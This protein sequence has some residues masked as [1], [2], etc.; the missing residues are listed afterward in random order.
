MPKSATEL[1]QMLALVRPLAQ[2]VEELTWH[3]WR[4]WVAYDCAHAGT[5][6]GPSGLTSEQALAVLDAGVDA[7][8]EAASPGVWALSATMA[9]ALT[10]LCRH[11][12]EHGYGPQLPAWTDAA[13]GVRHHFDAEACAW[14]QDA[15]GRAELAALR[16]VGAAA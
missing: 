3:L 11:L 4:L 16:G 15:L 6:P 1:T 2:T 5:E 12:T 14:R 8:P 7:G 13:N 10:T 9:R